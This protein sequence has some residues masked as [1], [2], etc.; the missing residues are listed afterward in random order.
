[1][2]NNLAIGLFLLTCLACHAPVDQKDE[3]GYFDLAEVLDGQV[4]QLG[5]GSWNSEK[6]VI[7]NDATD[8]LELQLDSVL[9]KEE[10]AIFQAFD[11]GRSQ[12]KNAF[13]IEESTSS[14]TYTKKTG[15]HQ[16]LQ[17]V[18]VQDRGNTRRITAE[19]IEETSIYTNQKHMDLLLESGVLKS[20]ALKGFQK[21]IFQDTTFFEM[22]TRI[23]N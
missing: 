13:E 22:N 19:I 17:W 8:Q 15:E 5:S 1:M 20:Y 23:L 21:M 14:T 16:S 10:L 11:P 4:E 7:V 2:R 6:T 3:T 12:F 9:L 18:K